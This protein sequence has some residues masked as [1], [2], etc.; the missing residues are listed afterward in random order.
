M[1]ASTPAV[2]DSTASSREGASSG[3]VF[4]LCGGRSGS[5]LL[6][7]L[8]DAH[9]DLAC[10]PETNLP[11][12]CGQLATVWSL[13]EGAPLSA[14]RGDEPPEI[15]EAA[16]AG[17]RHMMDLMV[18]SYLERRGKKRY[19]DK[20][21]GTAR[22]AELL[23]RVYPDAKFICLYRHPMDVVASGLE[24]CPWGLNGYGFDPYIASTPGNSVL[25]MAR[26]WADNVSAILRA[27]EQFPGHC[28]RVRYEDMV[29][30][31][32]AVAAGIFDFLGVPPAPGVSEICFAP[33][34]ERFGPADYK[35]WHTSKITDGSVGRGWSVPAGLMGPDMQNAVNEL[36]A[37]LGYLPVDDS[38]GTRE[39]PADLRL[40]SGGAQP[41]A[42]AADLADGAAAA[43]DASGRSPAAGQDGDMGKLLAAGMDRA[44]ERFTSRWAS[45]TGEAFCVLVL[46]GGKSA[47]PVRWRVDLVQRSITSPAAD[48]DDTA[49]DMIGPAEVWADIVAGRLNF[50]VAMRR[51]QIRYLDSGEA[52]P[53]VHDIRIGML[54]D[55]LGLT[56]W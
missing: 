30:D 23:L 13:I 34:R 1:A 24:A 2:A 53:A 48:N 16:I 27:E 8:L 21:L 3:A 22:L 54:A 37:R 10:P 6:R 9:P 7:F 52:P 38:W 41:E 50:S 17:V 20:S 42:P 33:D 12:L 26:F 4:V 36:A 25:A 56:S 44:G 47:P 46:P 51:C 14:N 32:E 45:V 29:S 40:P 55:L 35:I 43:G 49:W 39:P 18:G 11:A 31:P 19:C 5:T 28:H 15:P